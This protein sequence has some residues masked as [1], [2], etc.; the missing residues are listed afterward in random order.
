MKK[1]LFFLFALTML[2]ANVA[3][4]QE[5]KEDLI[6]AV[7]EGSTATY[8]YD[9]KY[10]ERENVSKPYWD[11]EEEAVERLTFADNITKIVFD[12]SMDKASLTS[13]AEWFSGLALLEE[14][15]GLQ[16]LHTEEVTNMAAMFLGCKSLTS[17]D[18][19]TFN[20][21]KVTDMGGMFL[22]CKSLTSLDLS[23]F[24][25]EKVTFMG[26]MFGS[27]Q[28]LTSLDLSSFNTANVTEM[29]AM[30]NQC[31][32]L[33]N[34][35]LSSFNTANVTNMAGMF[36]QCTALE[37]IDLTG[38]NTE[39]VTD[40]EQMFGMCETLTTLDLRSFD[41][42]KVEELSRM[43]YECHELT[44]IYCDDN[45]SIYGILGD[46]EM[47]A[48]CKKLVGGHGTTFNYTTGIDYA[49]PDGG[50]DAPG[51]FTATPQVYT[52]LE[53]DGFLYYYFDD[54][55]ALKEGLTAVYDADD[56]NWL[57]MYSSNK[58]HYA[59]IDESMK[60]AEMTSMNYLFA[61]LNNL[62]EIYDLQNLNTAS[63]TSM[64]GLF[65]DCQ[66]LDNLDLTT[67]NTDNVTDMA[68]MF[69]GCKF[70]TSL[71]L[72][73]FNTENVTDMAT[74]FYQC[75]A[76]E[77]INLSKFNTAN[78]TNM[79]GMFAEC[80]ALKELDLSNFNT[81]NV[82]NMY[83]TFL[84]CSALE[85]INLSSFNTDNV[86]DMAG[87]FA[88]CTALKALDLTHFN[89][90]NVKVMNMMFAGCEKLT[91]IYAKGYWDKNEVVEDSE[92]M[93]YGCKKLVGENGTAYDESRT[94]ITYARPDGGTDAPGYFTT[95]TYTVT[96][97]DWDAT[98]LFKETVK[99]GQDAKGPEKDPVR[100]GYIFTGWSK[101]VTNITSDLT[102]IAQ[103]KD[104]NATSLNDLPTDNLTG[105][106]V[107]NNGTLYILRNGTTYTIQGQHL[108]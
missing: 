46:D 107:I 93:F 16:Y 49:H 19:S 66:Y 24:N 81:A 67:F 85:S 92:D 99:D 72:T 7:V 9:N 41:F 36:A 31:T 30:F 94:D 71:D 56:S 53:K 65:A 6:Y 20:T 69:S 1:K 60:N 89:T 4:A 76:L 79:Y 43:F 105:K 32:A 45:L 5:I 23:T 95:P 44:T 52:A 97:L 57:N 25:I 91:T 64:H 96:F 59:V 51:Y 54:Q 33:E 104:K 8:Y 22:E 108:N 74:M 62:Y 27:C 34:I 102:V 17:L 48:G 82:N 101:P 14:I 40:M 3:R 37:N 68:S 21:E 11:M 84:Q 77:N 70:L 80:E 29:S 58:V 100:E 10:E 55:R 106:K 47:F 28:S 75:S 63:V 90:A 38:F 103:Y 88:E 26:S 2:F 18:L 12:P 35:D 42:G 86:T 78:L 87:M 15:D 13:T 73:S 50:K 98:P 83:G 39:N 61:G